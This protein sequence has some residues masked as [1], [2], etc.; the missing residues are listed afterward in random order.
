MPAPC[1]ELSD[2]FSREPATF[3]ALRTLS[4]IDATVPEHAQMP[5]AFDRR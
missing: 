3:T 5:L 4:P 1:H 2:T